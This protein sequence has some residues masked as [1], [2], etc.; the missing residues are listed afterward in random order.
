MAYRKDAGCSTVVILAT[1]LRKSG[2][3]ALVRRQYFKIFTFY[4]GIIGI[5]SNIGDLDRFTA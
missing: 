2:V 1:Y 4:S 3:I 5:R